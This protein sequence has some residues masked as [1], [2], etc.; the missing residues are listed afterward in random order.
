VSQVTVVDPE[1]SLFGRPLRLVSERSA[2][3][4]DYLIVALADGRHR[5]LRK[6]A[7]N[8]KS[9]PAD[10]IFDGSTLPRISVRTLVPLAYHL[11]SKFASVPTEVIRDARHSISDPSA[12]SELRGPVPGAGKYSEALVRATAA[13]ATADS[14]ADRRASASHDGSP[15]HP[16]R[17]GM[18]C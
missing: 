10:K 13:G 3:G 15:E 17:G 12:C 4:S 14:Q 16:A 9:T 6:T 1:H 8:F 5:V 18:P 2:K 11:R 7:T